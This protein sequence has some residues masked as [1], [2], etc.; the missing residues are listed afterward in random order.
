MR[1][2]ATVAAGEDGGFVA[3]CEDPQCSGHGLSP[4]NAL[5]ALRDEIRYRLE[6]CPCTSVDEGFVELNVRSGL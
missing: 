3:S 6:L 5:D 1:F 4:T 2:E